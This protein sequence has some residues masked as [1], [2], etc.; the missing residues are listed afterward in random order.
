MTG[1]K[2]PEG[3][4]CTQG[5][6]TPLPCPVGSY[7]NRTRNTHISDCL[8]CPPGFLCVSRGLSFPS[9]ICPAGSYCS[10]GGNNKS[11]DSIICS[12]GNRCPL[13]A[14]KQVPCLPGTYQNLPGQAD[15]TECP[16]GFF[17]AGSVDADT[18]Q[19]SG[20]HTPMLCPKG[21]YCPPGTQTGVAFPCPAG[22]FSSQ[23]G[24]SNNSDCELCPPGR[25]CSSSGLSAPSGVCSPGYLCIHGSVS[26][27]PE[28]GS[29]GGR[30][31]TGSYCPQ[32]TSYM[33]PCPAGT[34]SYIDGAVSVEA[35]QPCLPG[36]FC[37][38]AGASAPSGP[39]NPGFY[40]REGSR[41]STPLRN[42]TGDVTSSADSLLNYFHGDVC[43][44]GHY[45]PE[46]S[47]NPSPCPPGTFLGR[48]GAESED[49]C[50]D[51][52]S[53]SYCPFWAQ[54]S[55]DLSCPPGWVCP[56]GS[57]SGHQPGTLTLRALYS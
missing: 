31:S 57:V 17:C 52:Y 15:C 54:T 25:Y 46:G 41:T 35:C 34:F 22:T 2:C 51:C 9:H 29:T 44:A 33:V 39:C 38:E 7:S 18:G 53:G 24:M 42:A 1:D 43:P 48:S 10:S 49:D 50:E 11:Q 32:G 14:K 40:C 26:A 28:E 45:C 8:P 56:T 12:P 6:S 5:S 4:Y 36:H 23:M 16:A 13:G 37:S 3:H 19:V 20:T 21:H 30:C 55:V 47:A 27:Q